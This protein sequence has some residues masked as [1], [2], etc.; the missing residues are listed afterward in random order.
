MTFWQLKGGLVNEA[1]EAVMVTSKNGTIQST[2][3]SEGR[4]MFDRNLVPV[5]F[6]YIDSIVL[7]TLTAK[8]LLVVSVAFVSTTQLLYPH[9]CCAKN[10]AE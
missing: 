6:H 4:K 9:K 2:R 7:L 3:M 8:A 1:G 5:F 10:P